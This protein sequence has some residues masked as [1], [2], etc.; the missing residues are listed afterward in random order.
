MDSEFVDHG[1]LPRIKDD[2][3]R[4]NTMTRILGKLRDQ[5]FAL[6]LSLNLSLHPS[7]PVR[8]PLT[9]TNVSEF[10]LAIG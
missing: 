10:P 3:K 5:H 6:R 8:R 9:K 7:D 2:H 1:D 4:G